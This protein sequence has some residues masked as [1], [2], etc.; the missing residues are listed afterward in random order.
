METY[1]C[2]K[3]DNLI[4]LPTKE[5]DVLCSCGSKTK[6]VPK[7][8]PTGFSSV[9]TEKVQKYTNVDQ[10]DNLAEEKTKRKLV[11]YWTEDVPRLVASG[12]Y[13]LETMLKKDWVYY[14]AKGN[15][16]IRNSPPA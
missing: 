5:K 15:L 8:M 9:K 11:S 3:C 14:D 4:V 10:I 7:K 12:T 1:R 2:K 16:T 6:L 13:S